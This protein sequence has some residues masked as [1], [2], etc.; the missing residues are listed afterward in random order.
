MT[1]PGNPIRFNFGAFR[2]DTAYPQH[3]RDITHRYGALPI[4][5]EVVSGLRVARGGA[6][7]LLGVTPDIATFAKAMASGFPISIVAATSCP[8]PTPADR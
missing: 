2:V 4:F 7:E 3:V 1:P 5:D 8:T 6:Q